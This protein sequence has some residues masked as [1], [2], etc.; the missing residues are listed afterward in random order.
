MKQF[1][2]AAG[3]PMAENVAAIRLR[4]PRACSTPSPIWK[5]SPN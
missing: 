2:E 4:L 3:L 1:S 5:I